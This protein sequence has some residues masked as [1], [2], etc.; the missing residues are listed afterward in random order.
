MSQMIRVKVTKDNQ[1]NAIYDFFACIFHYIP[2]ND[3]K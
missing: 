3:G 1:I 2:D